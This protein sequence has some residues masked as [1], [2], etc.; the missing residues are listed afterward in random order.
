M[1]RIIQKVSTA[2]I[3]LVGID[4]HNTLNFKEKF[5]QIKDFDEFKDF[6]LE[7]NKIEINISGPNSEEFLKT[8][9]PPIAG[10]SDKNKNIVVEYRDPSNQLIVSNAPLT[11][12]KDLV[13]LITNI[14][15]EQSSNINAIGFNYSNKYTFNTNENIDFIENNRKLFVKSLQNKDVDVPLISSKFLFTEND[16]TKTYE[17]KQIPESEKYVFEVSANYNYDKFSTIKSTNKIKEI[18]IEEINNKFIKY[19]EEFEAISNGILAL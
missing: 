1:D 2:N 14:I 12:E 18:L 15:R 16:Y 19:S 9:I 11:N 10:F 4:Y 3:I 7:E 5:K 13:L 6:N 8:F 17:I